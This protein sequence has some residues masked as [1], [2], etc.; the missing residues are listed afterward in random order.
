MT[1]F[2]SLSIEVS[3]RRNTITTFINSM[4]KQSISSPPPN[5]IL[6]LDLNIALS[7]KRRL[8]ITST[9]KRASNG[10]S[11]LASYDTRNSTVEVGKNIAPDALK[12]R[13]SKKE[14]LRAV[15]RT[16]HRDRQVHRMGGAMLSSI[17][18][19]ISSHTMH[20]CKSCAPSIP[21]AFLPANSTFATSC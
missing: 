6:N 9:S 10:W 18:E 4:A 12:T 2:F 5:R 15:T 11:Q 20:S 19:L 1:S 14:E 21:A 13:P 8:W 16:A 3:L 7:V 17:H